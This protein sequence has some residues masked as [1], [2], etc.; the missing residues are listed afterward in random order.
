MLNLESVEEVF[1]LNVKFQQHLKKLEKRKRLETINN[2]KQDGEDQSSVVY[3]DSYITMNYEL[4]DQGAK[5]TTVYAIDQPVFM[6]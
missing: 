3:D 4:I 2:D 5:S 1:I 6:D